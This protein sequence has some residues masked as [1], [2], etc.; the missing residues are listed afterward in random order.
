MSE[1]H[2]ETAKNSELIFTVSGRHLC[3]SVHPTKEAQQWIS[4]HQAL[5]QNCRTIVVLGL[6]CGYHVRALKNATDADVVVLEASREVIQA[7]LRV[8]PL[9]LRESEIVHWSSV[10]VLK[11]SKALIAATKSSYAVLIH[12]PSAFGNPELYSQTK[13]FLLGRKSDGLR[14]LFEN[15]GL[16]APVFIESEEL[17]IKALDSVWVSPAMQ[18]LRELVV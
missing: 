6:G 12:E 15:R 13:E 7:A 1:V 9:D 8:H 3:S 2:F 10:E 4:Y 14:W 5:W 11:A 16:P 17:N 18:A